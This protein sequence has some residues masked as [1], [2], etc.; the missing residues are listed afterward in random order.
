MDIG[1]VQANGLAQMKG[2]SSWLSSL[3]LESEG[4]DLNKREFCD[5]LALRY[6]WNMKHLP[7]ICVCGKKLSVDHFMSCLKGGFI[8]QRHVCKSN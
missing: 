8:H 3:P 5:A 6:R 7:S 4:H 1:Q 2:G